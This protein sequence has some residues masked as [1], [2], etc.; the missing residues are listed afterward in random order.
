[1]NEFAEMLKEAFV[2]EEPFDARP[3]RE[4]LQASIRKYD[5]RMKTV[6]YMAIFA[7]TFMGVVGIY[8]F[9]WLLR[10]PDETSTRVLIIYAL[11][12]GWALG[13]VGFSKGWFAMMH[14]DIGLR[15]ELRR[16]QMMMLEKDG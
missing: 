8:C 3:G 13:A 5:A 1:M 12:F 15:K 10:A 9:V 7:V 6:R 4:A 11:V 14:N 2:G 16:M